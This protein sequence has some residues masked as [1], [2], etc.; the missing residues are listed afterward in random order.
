[1]VMV[2][3]YPVPALAR[4]GCR[5]EPSSIAAITCAAISARYSVGR[6]A[7]IVATLGA[8]GVCCV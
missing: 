2:M 1:M 6:P 3:V 7:G 5:V 4:F 8:R